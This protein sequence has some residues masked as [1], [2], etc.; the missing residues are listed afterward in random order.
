MKKI[1]ALVMAMVMLLGTLAVV[2][3]DKKEEEPSQ[4]VTNAPTEPGGQEGPGGK[5]AADMKVVA[6]LSG[7]I[8]DNGWNQIAYDSVK[9]LHDKYGIELEYIENIAVSDMAEYIRTYAEE[10]YDMVIIHGSQFKASA[11]ELAVQ[12]PDTKFCISYG[13]RVDENTADQVVDI[14]NLAYVGPVNMG[15]LIGAIMGILTD[16][17]KVVFL[18]GQDIPAITD[19]VS[20]IEEGVHLTNEGCQVTTDYLGTLTDADLA[21]ER[22]LAFIN[23]GYDVVSASANSAQL[24]CLYAAEEKGVY[25]LGFNGDQYSIAPEAVVLSV[26]RNY[27]AIY[28][29]VFNSILDGKWQSGMV[30]YTLKDNGTIVSDWHGWD[31]KLPQEKVDR[32][33]EVIEQLYEGKLGDY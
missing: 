4:P 22:A 3:C 29:D 32:I 33:K 9:N 12:Y 16:N 1:L 5:E 30:V 17:N 21:K 18:G 15:V 27:P 25:A 2:G 13:F 31:E 7:V 14:S 24:G 28:E 8:T 6:L 23:D 20:G 19:I 10:N 11:E 26:M